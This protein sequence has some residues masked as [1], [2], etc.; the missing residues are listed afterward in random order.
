MSTLVKSKKTSTAKGNK[1]G[2]AINHKDMFHFMITEPASGPNGAYVAIREGVNNSFDAGAT[3][4]RI[5]EGT[6]EGEKALFISDNG[7]GFTPKGIASAM[8]YANS[9][10]RRDDTSTI[11]ANGTGLK[12]LLALG[13]LE[14]T[15]LT[16]FTVGKSLDSPK[17]LEITFDYL[18]QLAKKKVKAEAF[19]S[20]AS[21]PDFWSEHL[22]RTTGTTVIL[23]NYDSRKIGAEK[24]A[25]ELGDHLTP[26]AVQ[27]VKVFIDEK[28]KAIPPIQFKGYHFGFSYDQPT[29][30]K[31]EFDIYYGDS[32]AEGP[33]ICGKLNAIQLLTDIRKRM[34]REKRSAMS[35]VWKTVSGHIYMER[36]N[37]YRVHNGAFSDDFFDTKAID[38]LE[39]LLTLVASELEELTEKAKS[40]E[41]LERGK[42][43]IDRIV[44]A[45]IAQNPG[46]VFTGGALTPGKRLDLKRP[47]ED[48]YIVPRKIHLRIGEEKPF[49]LNNVGTR[50]LDFGDATWKVNNSCV[51]I[52]SQSGGRAFLRGKT[53]G[54]TQAIVVGVF[55]SHTIQV[56]I[57]KS[58]P[59]LGPFIGGPAAIKPGTTHT[60]VINRFEKGVY[61]SVATPDGESGVALEVVPDNPK[62]VK[63]LIAPTVGELECMLV[64]RDI[65]SR[66]FVAQKKIQVTNSEVANNKPVVH[67]N[68]MNF[69]L[70]A[71]LY[72]P[73]TVAQIDQMWEEEGAFP[74]II[75]N[76]L[77]P[78][79]RNLGTMDAAETFLAAI[80]QT[81]LSYQVELGKTRAAEVAPI[82]EK[83]IEEMGA[84]IFPVKP[85][86]QEVVES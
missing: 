46:Q 16:I 31:V 4:I 53:E 37:V 9:A 64:V 5:I 10:Q 75:I 11:G 66:D 60:Y 77:H 63:L 74:K 42:N 1:I 71:D 81:A 80:A 3:E 20:N 57:T 72:Y 68:G 24:I 25:R 69:E 12:T 18:V 36:G 62:H 54:T 26:R 85:K 55:G 14:K 7:S 38:E 22:E 78:R 30:G 17:R 19:V 59:Y 70:E 32:S 23:T 27:H 21:I 39:E 35:K 84:L 65:K 50:V 28:W 34:P 29:L 2:A 52:T 61:W 47:N 73:D 76:P 51:E 40:T 41:T 6:F 33:T 44:A 49:V 79:V 67:I 15:K 43:L 48:V 82:A 13:K 83:F 56:E 58:V 8:G 86:K 45:S